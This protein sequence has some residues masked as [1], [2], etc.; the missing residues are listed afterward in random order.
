MV[1]I[2]YPAT[3]IGLK[4]PWEQAQ[5]PSSPVQ[6]S[7][8]EPNL[9]HQGE[10]VERDQGSSSTATGYSVE[11]EERSLIL[12]LFLCLF[13]LPLLGIPSPFALYLRMRGR[14]HPL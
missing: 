13:H 12:L 8:G 6:V 14:G 10:S 9:L 5:V 2:Y 11:G 3:E 1:F 7:E 4:A